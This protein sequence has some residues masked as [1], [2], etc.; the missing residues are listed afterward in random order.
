MQPKKIG[1]PP[2][3]GVCNYNPETV[4]LAHLPDESKGMGTKADDISACFACSACHDYIDGRGGSKM[5]L[6][7]T[8]WY[9]R[10]AVV[11]T[12]RVWI[13]KGLLFTVS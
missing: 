1:L 11:R 3:A 8:E 2:I 12:L 10:R 13:E 6:Q 7:D 9:M 5:A 4:V